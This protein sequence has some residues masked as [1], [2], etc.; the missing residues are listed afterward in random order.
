[1]SGD[2]GE[3]D[4]SM[5]P[6][7]PAEVPEA[8]GAD[9]G[10]GGDTPG[11][12]NGGGR[13]PRQG[14]RRWP[15]GRRSKGGPNGP[16]TAANTSGPRRPRNPDDPS[17]LPGADSRAADVDPALQEPDPEPI[18]I[19][20]ESARFGIDLKSPDRR[21]GIG[22][23]ASDSRRSANPNVDE[24]TKLHKLLA[25]AGLGSR[26]DMEEL[27]LAGRVSVNGQPSH[28]GQRISATD[29]VR[30]N[31]RQVK[32]RLPQTAPR[33]L[34]YHKPA[35]EI[36]TR[37]DPRQRVTVF[38]RLP[39]LTG[40]RWVAVGRLDFNTEGLLVF[41]TSGDL[42]NRLMHPRYGWEREYAVR[43]LG[44]IEDEVRD[45][46]LAGIQ[47]EDG[48]AAFLKIDDVGGDGANHW[49][50]VV[51]AE[52][53]N[54]EVRRIFE[55]VGL[56]VSRLVRIR[57]GPIGLPRQLSRGR[58]LELPEGEVQEL[59][60]LVK[61]AGSGSV[62]PPGTA[63][64]ASN[65]EAVA[66]PGEPQSARIG[67]RGRERGADRAG[68]KR[69][70]NPNRNQADSGFAADDSRNGNVALPQP[71]GRADQFDG[72]DFEVFDEDERQPDFGPLPAEERLSPEQLDDEWQPKAAN[73]HQEGITRLVR[74]GDAGA[75]KKGSG[76]A[77][78]NRRTRPGGGLGGLAGGAALPGIQ[79]PM[80][81]SSFRQPGQGRGGSGG[82]AG[83][84]PGSSGTNGQQRRG[85][86]PGKPPGRGRSRGP[87][88][89]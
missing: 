65:P 60:L 30:V 5:V 47:L 33:V 34:L 10:A 21:P 56:T 2:S 20:A 14:G 61:N 74:K 59:N 12:E 52:G 85:P 29:Q 68:G 63:V 15:G 4:H 28:V 22:R 31:G 43:I 1:M 8:P 18:P 62:G 26:R 13:R 40:S 77:N 81:S 11:V 82:R 27:I 78:R 17:S 76:K 49:Y 73:A 79:G 39:R 48:P 72:D 6:T 3:I 84:G 53:R 71:Q 57:F 70:Q 67:G 88:Q 75:A 55:Q 23:E 9:Q 35:G 54:R 41:T 44:R 25:D 38:E 36:T 86:R 42:A 50:R 46:L 45:Q 58:W 64:D 37:E 69:R 16:N 19:Q 66:Q 32:L 51:L 87:A 89:G 83:S 24:S 7:Q 80:T